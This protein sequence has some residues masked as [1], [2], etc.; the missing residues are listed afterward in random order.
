MKCRCGATGKRTNTGYYDCPN[1]DKEGELSVYH[2]MVAQSFPPEAKNWIVIE[3]DGKFIPCAG[4]DEAPEKYH[5]D[6]KQAAWKHLED[7][8]WS[9]VH[10]DEEEDNDA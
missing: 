9:R 7:L 6:T 2:D 10:W 3:R 4:G 1:S 5:Q 8:Y